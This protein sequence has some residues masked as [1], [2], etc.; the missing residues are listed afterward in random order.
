M[1]TGLRTLHRRRLLAYTRHPRENGGSFLPAVT[2][3][4]AKVV[5]CLSGSRP[6]MIATATRRWG[7]PQRAWDTDGA[8][9]GDPWGDF[10]ESYA[11]KIECAD[12]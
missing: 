6:F 2:R 8:Q 9:I 10:P 1:R 4:P 11:T 3:L 12:D 7:H 5:P